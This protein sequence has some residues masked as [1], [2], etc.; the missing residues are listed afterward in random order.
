MPVPKTNTTM[1]IW[2]YDY[3]WELQ[4]DLWTI[5]ISANYYTRNKNLDI[6]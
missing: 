3:N 6:E 5:E 4:P 1:Q 2:G